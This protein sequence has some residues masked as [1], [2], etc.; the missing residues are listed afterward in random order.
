M[1][2]RVD[3]EPVIVL[4]DESQSMEHKRAAV[5]VE[6]A[7]LRPDRIITFGD[8]K[9][10]ERGNGPIPLYKPC[11]NSPLYDAIGY[12]LAIEPAPN[13]IIVLTDGRNKTDS[14]KF[15]PDTGSRRFTCEQ[16]HKLMKESKTHFHF[17]TLD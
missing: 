7:R 9:I 10:Q 4:L 11:G 5:M 2:G 14:G 15:A 1:L 17:Q 13:E 12:C 16:I 3:N 6:I 8:H